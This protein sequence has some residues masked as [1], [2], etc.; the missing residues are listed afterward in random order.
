MTDSLAKIIERIILVIVCMVGPALF[1]LMYKSTQ[2]EVFVEEYTRDYL[3]SVTSSGCIETNDYVLYREALAG[4]DGFDTEL[5]YTTYHEEPVYGM[6]TKAEIE[7]FFNDRNKWDEHCNATEPPLVEDEDPMT[8]RMQKY[9]NATAFAKIMNQGLPIGT[10]VASPLY[11][12]TAVEPLQELYVGEYLATVVQIETGERTYY[13]EADAIRPNVAAYSGPSA[14]MFTLKIGGSFTSATVG[15]RVW[16]RQILCGTCGY[17]YTCT[18]EAIEGYK[19]NGVWSYCPSCRVNVR[20]ITSDSPIVTCLVGTKEEDINSVRFT[21]EYY[22]GTTEEL[23]LK[24]FSNNYSSSYAG[25]QNITVSYKGYNEVGVCRIVSICPPCASCGT[26]ITNRNAFDCSVYPKCSD[27]MA[28]VPSYLGEYAVVPETFNDDAIT[29]Q[30]IATGSF[31]MGRNDYLKLSVNHD[32]ARVGGK[33]S[34]LS[35]DKD[36]YFKMGQRVRRTGID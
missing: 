11:T 3:E 10:G 5:H 35:S 29:A 15:A 7:A 16:P 23:M 33:Y 4:V 28:A 6:H 19:A 1:F 34:F 25:E 36:I 30:L 32:G 24:D 12:Y 22:D 21:V 20:K 26:T 13:A 14:Y 8:L 18:K 31:P 9:T 27:C 2:K 17:T